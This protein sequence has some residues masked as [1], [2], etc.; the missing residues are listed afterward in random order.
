MASAAKG[1]IF[2]TQKGSMVAP[3]SHPPSP[4]PAFG[5]LW[6]VSCGRIA[7]GETHKGAL[8]INGAPL[9]REGLLSM[10]S[11]TSSRDLLLAERVNEGLIKRK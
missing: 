6:L 1:A 5:A 2:S 9:A 10:P 4:K 7:A 11:V 8:Q 3:M